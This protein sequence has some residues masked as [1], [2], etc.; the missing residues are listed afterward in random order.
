MGLLVMGPAG[1]LI[2]GPIVGVGALLGTGK[3]HDLLDQGIRGEWHAKV[4][5]ASGQL[6]IA[7]LQARHRQID[8]LT[9]RLAKLRQTNTTLP[10]HLFTWL[11][12]R[13]T[14]DLIAAI[15]AKGQIPTAT[16]LPSAME[17]MVEASA[18]DMIDPDVL[19]ARHHLARCIAAKPTTTDALRELS[20]KAKDAVKGRMMEKPR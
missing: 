9:R 10:P 19:R 20:T 3:A 12:G 18:P 4:L 2:L 7:L 1:A 13:M 11:E 14:D 8:A 6:R 15:E 17:L 16:D 5:P